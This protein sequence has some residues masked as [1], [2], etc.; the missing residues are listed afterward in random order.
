MTATANVRGR[1]FIADD[2]LTRDEA[3]AVLDRAAALK[4]ERRRG[5]LHDGLLRGRTVG[6]LFA[7]PSTRTRVGFEADVA[8]LGGQAMD[9]S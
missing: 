5:T 6:L 8:Q 3:V 2:D 4:E 1:D 9:L 7:K